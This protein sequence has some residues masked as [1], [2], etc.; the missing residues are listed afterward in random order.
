MKAIINKGGLISF[1]CFVIT[2]IVSLT[3]FSCEEVLDTV[4]DCVIPNP[5]LPN[6]QLKTAK[7]G[8]P[9]SEELQANLKNQPNVDGYIYSFNIKGQLPEGIA[10]NR[11]HRT[12]LFEG[13]PTETGAFSIN[14]TVE[15]HESIQAIDICV[16]KDTREYTLV[17]SN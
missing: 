15:V 14:I 5:E 10:I 3:L 9:Y 4:K 8:E 1:Y 16:K 13:I 7:L 11:F 12:L 2:I 17:V 6:K